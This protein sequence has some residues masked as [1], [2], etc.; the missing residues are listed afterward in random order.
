MLGSSIINGNLAEVDQPTFT[1][2]WPLYMLFVQVILPV[3]LITAAGFVFARKSGAD[4]QS[5]ANSVLYLFAPSLVFSA[6]IKS[7]VES[8]LLGRLA[9]FMALYTAF[10]CLLAFCI[11]RWRKFDS[12][13]TRAFTLTTSMVN[14]GNFGLPLVFFAYGEASLDV[15][16]VLFVL[17][18][19][20]LG[21]LAILIAQGQ[22]VKWQTAL[23]NTLKIP[24]FYGV[25]L[26]IL[27]KV[28]NLQPPEFILRT[29]GLL[30]QA[31]IPL[32]LVL[33]G[34]QLSRVKIQGN[35]GFFGLS[36]AVRLLIGPLLAVALVGLLGFDEPT[37]KIVILQTSAPSAVLPLLYTIR[38]G[39]R[40]DLV[41]GTILFSTLCS[42]FTLTALLYWLA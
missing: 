29:T 6:L 20:P 14:I 35:W 4:L 40:P 37:R 17:F 31:A 28:I 5:L 26:A 38:F 9:L 2:F 3:F 21:T 13:T 11:S 7:H 18:N 8:D 22:G 41:S 24:I 27:C 36:T 15:S 25:A 12:D 42:A 33:L 34:M 1:L 16:I 39:T 19:I 23:N 32:M 10:L 30:G